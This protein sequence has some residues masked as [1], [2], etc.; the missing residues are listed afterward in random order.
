ME[1]LFKSLQEKIHYPRV[2]REAWRQ[3]MQM[4]KAMALIPSV[5]MYSGMVNEPEKGVFE[6]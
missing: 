6:F 4:A 3:R 5:L 1:N 2:P